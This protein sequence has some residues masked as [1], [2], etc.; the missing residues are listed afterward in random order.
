MEGYGGILP[1]RLSVK[2]SD[3]DLLD[4]ERDLRYATPLSDDDRAALPADAVTFVDRIWAER[5]RVAG[6]TAAAGMSTPWGV[7]EFIAAILDVVEDGY[8]LVPQH[9]DDEGEFLSEGEDIAPG[10]ATAFRQ[11][12]AASTWPMAVP[13]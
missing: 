5:N 6:V 13:R 9:H 3:V 11:A 8:V 7:G 2:G 10:S 12:W 4:L 1:H